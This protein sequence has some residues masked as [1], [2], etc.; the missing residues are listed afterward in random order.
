MNSVIG[1]IAK[2][3]QTFLSMN[4]LANVGQRLR[5]HQYSVGLNLLPVIIPALETINAPILSGNLF[6]V[7]IDKPTWILSEAKMHT[8]VNLGIS[9]RYMYFK[10]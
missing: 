6:Y 5:T 8:E 10:L 2:P 7:M 9:R 3:A 4:C 1:V